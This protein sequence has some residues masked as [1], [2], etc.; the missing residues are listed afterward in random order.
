[1]VWGGGGGVVTCVCASVVIA[2]SFSRICFVF[3]GEIPLPMKNQKQSTGRH[4][5]PDEAFV[6][7]AVILGGIS[8]LCIFGL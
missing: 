4:E 3:S 1:M 5:L 2:M 6:G 8:M 7:L